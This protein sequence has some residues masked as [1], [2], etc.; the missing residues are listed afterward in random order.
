[1]LLGT[2]RNKK[3]VAP[4][5]ILLIATFS[6][7]L[8]LF[9]TNITPARAAGGE[10]VVEFKDGWD[11]DP[12]PFGWDDVVDGFSWL[13]DQV[14]NTFTGNNTNNS[15]SECECGCGVEGCSC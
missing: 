2:L 3:F 10:I 8:Y 9:T 7:S 15:S 12:N 11:D 6:F 4:I 5:A 14:I 13:M 1:M